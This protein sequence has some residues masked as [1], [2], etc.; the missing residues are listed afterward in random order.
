M[1][2]FNI[3]L[4]ETALKWMCT[5]MYKCDVIKRLFEQHKWLISKHCLRL[6]C[7]KYFDYEDTIKQLKKYIEDTFDGVNQVRQNDQ[8]KNYEEAI[9]QLINENKPKNCIIIASHGEFKGDSLKGLSIYDFKQ[10]DSSKCEIKKY[11]LPYIF[12]VKAGENGDSIQEWLK[13]NCAGE[14]II[15]IQDPYMFSD[16]KNNSFKCFVNHYLPLIPKETQIELY[17]MEKNN[18]T[19]MSE[20]RAKEI[21]S[22]NGVEERKITAYRMK[23][24]HDRFIWGDKWAIFI[25]FG[26]DIFSDDG[27][28]NKNTG[29]VFCPKDIFPCPKK[30]AEI[31]PDGKSNIMSLQD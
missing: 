12:A 15:K 30:P 14:S 16:K 11:T 9:V 8:A 7:E 17:Y 13:N 5:D 25:G 2:T 28:I 27:N 24:I 18:M 10:I 21:L 1:H 4:G 22:E 20:D 23:E 26:T 29:I 19:N 3:I 6:F 31:G